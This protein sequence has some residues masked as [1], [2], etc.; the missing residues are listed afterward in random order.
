MSG[1][2]HYNEVFVQGMGG[3]KVQ[4]DIPELKA[5]I[6]RGEKIAILDAKISFPVS[7]GTVVD[8]YGAPHRLLL[9]QPNLETGGNSVIIDFVDDIAPP[10]IYWNTYSNYNGR[11]N[12]SSGVYEFHFTRFLQALINEYIETGE[13][14]FNGF[15]LLTP[16]DFPLTPSRVVL[17]TDL[18]SGAKVSVSYSKLN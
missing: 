2:G 15:Y 10:D 1:S 11:Y 13:H 14:S 9:F 5:L 7:P 17:N 3:T 16:S 8:N 12:S 4:L 18:I 6:E